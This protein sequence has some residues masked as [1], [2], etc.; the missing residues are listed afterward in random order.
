MFPDIILAQLLHL[1]Y[2]LDIK[3]IKN[4][5]SITY[6]KISV[7]FESQTCPL[8]FQIS[9]GQLHYLS[10]TY[11]HI[12]SFKDSQAKIL[13]L[14]FLIKLPSFCQTYVIILGFFCSKTNP[15]MHVLHNQ[16]LLYLLYF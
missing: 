3:F 11:S 14:Y 6:T 12:F 2:I 5:F 9:P 16:L 7:L 13:Y 10:L 4:I 8:P 1:K 15:M